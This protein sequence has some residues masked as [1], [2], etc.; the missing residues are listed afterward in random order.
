MELFYISFCFAPPFFI[1]N[2]NELKTWPIEHTHG[3]LLNI[4]LI[5]ILCCD[6]NDAVNTKYDCDSLSEIKPFYL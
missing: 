4:F 6:E 3:E 2:S 5:S 1:Q